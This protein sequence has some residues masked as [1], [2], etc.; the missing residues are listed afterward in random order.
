VPPLH[1]ETL[2]QWA[3][4]VPHDGISQA[5]AATTRRS[6]FPLQDGA[7]DDPFN[8][9]SKYF[10]PPLTRPAPPVPAQQSDFRPSSI[11]DILHLWAISAIDEW[12][13]R[14]EADLQRYVADPAS[15]RRTNKPLVIDQ[16]GF[17]PR[18]QGL[19]W[20][21]RS[22]VRQLMRRDAPGTTSLSAD[23]IRAAVGPAYLDQELLNCIQYGVRM[24][25]EHQLCIVLLP[26]LIS[27][28]GAGMPQ[29]HADVTRMEADRILS[30]HAS[31]PFIPGVILPQGSNGKIHEPDRRRRITDAGVP[32]AP[33][34]SSVGTAI[35]PINVSVL[36]PRADGSSPHAG[37][38]E[39]QVRPR[40]RRLQDPRQPRRW[41][42]TASLPR[43]A[44]SSP[45]ATTSKPSSISSASTRPSSAA[46]SSP[47]CS[48]GG[49]T[50]RRSACSASAAPR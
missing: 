2:R 38:E 5:V 6:R 28:G 22:A 20:D 26:N 3:Y 39:A 16:D 24:P 7:A 40:T 27:I 43:C 14:E 18:A 9:N 50:S 8:F 25:A 17:K 48:T 4:R 41:R 13:A 10:D 30:V 12:F 34:T 19:F 15:R 1:R 11:K 49:S 44:A 31:M 29:H 45:H 42:T 35:V 21:L 33:L 37:G 46:S 36:I 23:A 47:S 32:R